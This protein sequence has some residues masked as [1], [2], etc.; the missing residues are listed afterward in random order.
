MGTGNR[1]GFLPPQWA[2]PNLRFLILTNQEGQAACRGDQRGG[3]W[4]DGIEAL[5]GAKRDEMEGVAGQG[6]RARSFCK[7]GFGAGCDYIDVGQCKGANDLA[8]E[9]GFLVVGL[10]QGEGEVWRPELEVKPRK[11]SARADVGD[12]ESSRIS[13]ERRAEGGCSHMSIAREKMARGKE[14]FA[15]VASDD[16]VGIANGREIHTRIPAN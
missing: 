2:V 14:A 16:V 10:D 1:D 15:E 8:Q 12:G 6:W 13:L 5:D 9:G 4:E 7:Q 3:D 11:S